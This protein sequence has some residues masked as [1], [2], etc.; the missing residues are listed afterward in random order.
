MDHLPFNVTLAKLTI[1]PES[2]ITSPMA[3]ITVLQNVPMVNM[4]L[5]AALHANLAT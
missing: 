5:T 1:P 4:Q 3:P 2:I